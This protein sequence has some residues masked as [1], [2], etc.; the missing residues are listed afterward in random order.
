MP[1]STQD[2]TQDNL[3]YIKLTDTVAASPQITADDMSAVAA[4]GYKIVINN[5]PDGE[6]MGQPT[7]EELRQAAEAAGL[8]YHYYP[9]N[10]FNYPG[11]DLSA[12]A[13]LFDDPRGVF[14]FCRSGTRSSNL[15]ISSR[16]GDA[17]GQARQHAQQLGFDVSMSMA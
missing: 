16:S 14:A 15:W 5:R 4:A 7:S 12:M 1:D 17:Q 3:R 6:A 8:E 9:L 10:A 13:A 2:N 11:D